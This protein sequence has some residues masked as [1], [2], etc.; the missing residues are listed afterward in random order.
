MNQA[1][2]TSANNAEVNKTWALFPINSEMYNH[3]TKSTKN[4][5]N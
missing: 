5:N 4:N 3:S 1:Q 2:E